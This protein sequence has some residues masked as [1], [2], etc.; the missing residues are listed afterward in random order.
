MLIDI[1]AISLDVENFRHAKVSHE[2]DAIRLLL[3]DEK[4]HKVTELAKDIVDQESLDPSSL[5]IVTKDEESPNTFIALE[6]NRRMAA[7]KTMITPDLAEGLNCY[8]IFKKLSDKFLSLSIQKLDCVVL[9]RKEAAKWI[10]RKHYKGMGGEAVQ[11][12]N[13]V[14]TARSDASE[15]VF[16]R[17]MTS[18]AFLEENGIDA[19]AIRDQISRKTTTVERVLNSSY[20]PTMLG[21]QYERTGVLRAE[22]GDQEGAQILVH[23]LLKAMAEPAFVETRVSTKEQQAEWLEEFRPLSVKFSPNDGSENLSDGEGSQENAAG[24]AGVGSRTSEASGGDRPVGDNGSEGDDQP[25]MNTNAKESAGAG[26]NTK[27]VRVR[28]VLA[29]KG[30]RISNANLNKFYRELRKLRVETNPY[31]S[32]AIIRV[33]LEKATIDFLEK[34]GVPPLNQ[35]P[36]STWHDF[37]IKL[38]SKVD[39]AVKKLDPNGTNPRLSAAR[40]VANG[41]RDRLHSLDEL[42]SAIHDHTKL[43]AYSEI[44]TIWDRF[45]PYFYELFEAIENRNN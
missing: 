38:R 26:G 16:T 13:A 1:G 33:F 10:K 22:N 35:S 4:Y 2:R 21:L 43:P 34:T 39:A 5:L 14:A 3:S 24:H 31:I 18:L 9:D 23:A 28:K 41:N 17:W 45:H 8:S 36:G 19:E 11:P 20:V 29:D 30:L 32:A 7:L 37:G 12:W 27:S 44:I 25:P 15:G 42:N 40:D 6:G